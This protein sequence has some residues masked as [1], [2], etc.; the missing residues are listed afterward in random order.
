[1]TATMMCTLLTAITIGT[2]STFG[3]TIGNR[4]GTSDVG[5]AD[6]PE[7]NASGLVLSARIEK[8]TFNPGEPI[9]LRV[10]VTNNSRNVLVIVDT[11]HPEWD[12]KLDVRNEAGETVPLT[13]D[14]ERLMR[15]ISIYKS[16]S[17]WL[18]PGDTV[19]ADF[20]INKLFEMNTPGTYSISS[21]RK[22]LTLD[23]SAYDFATSNT[24]KITIAG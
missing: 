14:G 18:Y 22:F 24:V 23:S 13:K 16:V 9:P 7:T 20:V 15:N 4:S 3:V 11:Y 17:V 6:S 8:P 21:K 2:L 1:M 19:H 10:S 5:P 12:Y